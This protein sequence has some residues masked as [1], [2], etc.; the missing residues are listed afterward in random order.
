MRSLEEQIKNNF[1]YH[2]PKDLELKKYNRL[3]LIRCAGKEFALLIDK[4]CPNSSE[5]SE[6]VIKIEEAV[7]WANASIA[8]N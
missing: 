5:K 1:K 6:A 2:E 4:F 7:M 8:R 3:E